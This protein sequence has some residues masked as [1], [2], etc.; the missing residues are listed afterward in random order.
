[1]RMGRRMKLLVA[2][3]SLLAAIAMWWAAR[4]D[5]LLEQLHDQT[6][7]RRR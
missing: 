3:G 5:Y 1:M 7:Q 2:I 6:H 4:E